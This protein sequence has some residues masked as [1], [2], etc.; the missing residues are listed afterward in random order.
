MHDGFY[1]TGDVASRDA[2]GYITYVGRTDDVFKSSDYRIS[3]FEL[4]S[5]LIEHA[6]VAEAAVVPSPDP[7]RLAVPKAY[8]VLVEGHAPDAQTALSILQHCNE[9]VSPYKRIRRIEF[10]AVAEN[11]LG[12]DPPRGA[13]QRRARARRGRAAPPAGILGRG[14]AWP[15]GSRAPEAR[16]VAPRMPVRATPS[17]RSARSPTDERAAVED[18]LPSDPAGRMASPCCSPRR[19]MTS[20]GSARRCSASGRS[21]VGGLTSRTIGPHGFRDAGLT[22]F[23]LPASRFTVADTLIENVSRFGLP[24]A[25]DVVRSLRARLE[26]QR[27]ARRA[28]ISSACCWW[29]PRR[30]ARSD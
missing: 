17:P 20:R 30:A 5:V 9:R 27:V 1:H 21:A 28:R 11:H 23:H 14:S 7:L 19:A 26:R 6:A 16:A 24:D 22:G 29:M 10:A 13:A 12:K 25:R 8:V 3:P 15:E 2:D 4:E 18:D